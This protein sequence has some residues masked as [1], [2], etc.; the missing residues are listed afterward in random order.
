MGGKPVE[1]AMSSLIAVQEDAPAQGKDQQDG[2]Q[3]ILD[4]QY[5]DADEDEQHGPHT[6]QESP[7]EI[8]NV[9]GGQKGDH[10]DEEND[11]SQ[12]Q[13]PAFH[14]YLA[15]GRSNTRPRTIRAIGQIICQLKSGT[16]R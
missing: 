8:E 6:P 1:P 12:K 5:H 15:L 13:I 11:D 3:P 2:F 7:A 9:E 14:D 16:K 10:A 4:G